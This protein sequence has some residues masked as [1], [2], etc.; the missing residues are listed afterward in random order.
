MARIYYHEE[1]LTGKA[2]ENDVINLQLFDF[3]SRE[4]NGMRIQ[5]LFYETLIYCVS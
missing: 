3:I 5:V 4:F 1:K 2:F